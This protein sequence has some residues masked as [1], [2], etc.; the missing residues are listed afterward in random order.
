MKTLRNIALCAL[1]AV[2]GNA[3]ADEL[4]IQ[5]ITIQPEG[6]TD[7]AVELEN[8]DRAYIMTEFYMS[9][10]TGV[11]IAKDE[12]GELLC[13]P[14]SERFDRTHSLVVEQ[15]SDGTY[16]FLIYSSKNKP[17]KGSSGGLLT[18]TL[19]ADANATPGQYEGRIFGQVFSDEDRTE[20]NPANVTFAVTVKEAEPQGPK[21][22]VNQDGAVDI[23]DVVA[24][25]NIMA[26]N[27]T[28]GYNGDVN[29]DGA[30]DIADVVAIYNIMAGGK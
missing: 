12:D 7:V 26:G 23:A 21:G 15:G 18:M 9:L 8:P 25:Y 30:T 1:L 10:P 24:V 29:E 13:E 11:S 27:N 5:P 16:H 3:L 28:N 6:Q 17:L 19:K 4:R 22:D 14:N 20:Y 2:A